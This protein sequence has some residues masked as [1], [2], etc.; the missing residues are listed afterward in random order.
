M[1]HCGMGDQRVCQVKYYTS[2]LL[3]LMALLLPT[4]PVI[5]VV[6]YVD[7]DAV[8][9]YQGTISNPFLT[10]QDGI[11]AASAGDTAHVL[12]GVYEEQVTLK[13]G[14]NLQGT[15]MTQCIIDG[16]YDGAVKNENSS[17]YYSNCLFRKNTVDG[18][19]AQGGAACNSGG[20]PTYVNC[21]FYDNTAAFLGGCMVNTGSARS[22]AYNCILWNNSSPQI[23]N[24]T[25][26]TVTAR[27]CDIEGG[28]ATNWNID[29]D[30]RF[31]DPDNG[32]F[33]L[34]SSSPCIDA[35]SNDLPPLLPEYDMDGEERIIDG[36]AIPGAVIDMGLDEVPEGFQTAE[37]WVDDDYTHGGPND[38]HI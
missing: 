20:Y 11:D 34:L 17:S 37:V 3:I 19:F 30:P 14:V 10:I 31:V 21:V 13:S 1:S 29:L 5:G 27:N 12:Q 4:A 33:H 25:S 7:D 26:S 22:K 23:F 15:N 28:Y 24:Y 9:P 8:P 16:D 35:G 38:G 18:R 36:D 32:D 2:V 6:W